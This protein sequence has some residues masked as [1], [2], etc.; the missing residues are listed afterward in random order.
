MAGRNFRLICCSVAISNGRPS[1]CVYDWN[2]GDRPWNETSVEIHHRLKIEKFCHNVTSSLYSDAT[3]CVGLVSEDQLPPILASLNRELL[4]LH[5]LL[6]LF[7]RK[8]QY[9]HSKSG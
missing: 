4:T 5:T 1:R 7:T 6:P 2:L 3:D 9:T 8:P